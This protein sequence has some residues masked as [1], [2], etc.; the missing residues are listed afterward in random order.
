ML[1]NSHEFLFV[2]LPDAHRLLSHRPFLP[3]VGDSLAH[4]DVARLLGL[5]AAA[6][7]LIS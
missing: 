5:V 1:F 7:I 3:T 4:S 6:N 2:F